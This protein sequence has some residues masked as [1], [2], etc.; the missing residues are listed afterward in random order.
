VNGAKFGALIALLTSA[1]GCVVVSDSART[2]EHT[3]QTVER[4]GAEFVNVNV[5]MGAGELKM[6][7]GAAPLMDCDFRYNAPDARPEVQYNV[8]SSRG[9]LIVRQASTHHNIGGNSKNTWDL[10]LNE[11][12]PMDLS[13]KVGAGEGRLDLGSLALHTLDIE[14]GAGEL[15]LDLTGHPRN[16]VDVRIRGGVGEATVRLPRRA[17]L[18]VEAHGGLGGINAQG[19]TKRG[20]RWVNEPSGD[21]QAAMH[22]D[23]SGGIGSINL[24]CE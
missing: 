15:K 2:M 5:E 22:V 7:G 24:I 8:T 21:A 1:G 12:V 3:S 6:R 16:D 4:K 20:D 17:R 14:M 23:V 11:D 9:T 13:I 10:R 18:D 19:L